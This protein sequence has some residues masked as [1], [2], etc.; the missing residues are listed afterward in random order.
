[1]APG[2]TLWSIAS[3]AAGSGDVRAMVD[4]IVSINSLSVPDVSAGQTLRVPA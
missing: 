3:T 2:E 4:E 1:V